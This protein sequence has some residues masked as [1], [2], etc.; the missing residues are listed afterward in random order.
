MQSNQKLDS[1]IPL[2]TSFK[3]NNKILSSL[4]PR[5]QLLVLTPNKH[6]NMLRA[7]R[8][9]NLIMMD[10]STKME[11]HHC[12]KVLFDLVRHWNWH[13]TYKRTHNN[14]DKNA[15]TLIW[16]IVEHR[17]SRANIDCI[18]IWM[19]FAIVWKDAF[20]RHIRNVPVRQLNHV[21][22]DKFHEPGNF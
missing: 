22:L 15:E 21:L 14:D 12:Y 6:H 19:F 8:I 11:T 9:S 7:Y 1:P 13:K 5:P 18:G 2:E 10:L 3:S 16:A 4:Q 17:F 20:R